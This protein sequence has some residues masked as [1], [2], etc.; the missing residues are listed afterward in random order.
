MLNLQKKRISEAMQNKDDVIQKL[1]NE[2][3]RLS[4]DYERE[5]YRNVSL[6]HSRYFNTFSELTLL[7]FLSSCL[8]DLLIS[9]ILS[10]KIPRSK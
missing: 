4:E 9:L 8:A 10:S 7:N 2:F 5:G 6:I 1:R 3:N